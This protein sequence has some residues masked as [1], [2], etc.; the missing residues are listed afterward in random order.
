[1]KNNLKLVLLI[2]LISSGCSSDDDASAEAKPI[3]LNFDFKTDLESWQGDFADYPVGEETFYELDVAFSKLPE[4]LDEDQ[5]AIKQTGNNHSDDLFMFLKRKVTGLQPG[6]PYAVTFTIEFA[7]NAADNSFGV[8]G[9]P[10]S[11]VFIKAGATQIEPKKEVDSLAHYRMNI[12]KG[13]QASE[14]KNMIN[15]GDFSNGLEEDKYALKSLKNEKPFN[16]TADENGEIWLVVGTD[17]GFEAPTTI[18][19]N[20]ISIVLE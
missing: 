13:N 17:S 3:E 14:G 16:V 6:Q 2:A 1:M 5:N 11:S 15:L 8:G 18:Y 20:K 9:S 19:Y 10:G 12:D 7:T 4:T